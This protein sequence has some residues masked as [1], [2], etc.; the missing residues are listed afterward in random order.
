MKSRCNS[1]QIHEN[2]MKT[3][4]H[5][6]AA[7]LVFLNMA[8]LTKHCILYIE[9]Y[10]DICCV[11][12]LSLKKHR[13]M[14]SPIETARLIP[15]ITENWSLGICFRSKNRPEL[16]SER[17]NMPKIVQKSRSRPTGASQL[18]PAVPKASQQGPADCMPANWRP[19]NWARSRRKSRVLWM[20]SST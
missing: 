15:N 5:V 16:P 4:T 20:V 13:K 1:R 8:T 12:E 17:P 10:F 2:L 18:G 7:S 3:T 11:F 14:E 6:F 9:S 19:A